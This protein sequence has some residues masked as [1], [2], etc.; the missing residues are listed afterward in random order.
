MAPSSSPT[1]P[2]PPYSAVP[3]HGE[4]GLG[5]RAALLQRM[6]WSITHHSHFLQDSLEW[7]LWFTKVVRLDQWV[8]SGRERSGG[9]RLVLLY[10]GNKAYPAN[11]A[12]LRNTLFSAPCSE[13]YLGKAWFWRRAHWEQFKRSECVLEIAEAPRLLRAFFRTDRSLFIPS[14]I[15]GRVALTAP[16]I[17]P[18]DH[19]SFRWEMRMIRKNQL[20][21]TVS[22]DPAQLRLFYDTMYIPNISRVHQDGAVIDSFDVLLQ[23]LKHG[24]ILFI[25]RDGEAIAGA[26][27][28]F[29]G[30]EAHMTYAG[31][32]EGDTAY[33]RLGAVGALYYFGLLHAHA[34]GC[35]RVAFGWSRAFLEDGV[36]Q[37][38]RQR[39]MA[40]THPY[41]M[42]FSVRARIEAA[43]VQDFLR[44]N[45]FIFLDHGGFCGA[46]CIPAGEYWSEA[47]TVS[48]AER[49]LMAGMPALHL[50]GLGP[51]DPAPAQIPAALADKI[52]LHPAADL[53]R[54]R[55]GRG[56]FRP[57]R[58]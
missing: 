47:E 14:W 23:G 15:D 20:G 3:G 35:A 49:Y 5:R 6:R 33:V 44:S 39:G 58:V 46:F 12:Y 45:P 18:F 28:L 13:H 57:R 42:G 2:H 7:I 38:K 17:L 27:M 29:A 25:T 43:A 56:R 9:H 31:I 4:T 50:Y 24:E 8:L 32:K 34:R 21:Y 26:L 41:K 54:P 22:T 16:A 1:D 40:L 55:G 11:R 30:R 48:R 36:L 19:Y 10:A 51:A 52:S 53:F 37:F